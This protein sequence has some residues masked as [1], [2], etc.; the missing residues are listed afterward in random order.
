MEVGQNA[1]RQIVAPQKYQA[2]LLSLAHEAPLAGHLGIAKTRDRLLEHFYRPGIEKS[3]K[4]FCKSCETC[5]KVGKPNQTI[6]P[7]PL[8]PIPTTGEPFDRILMDCVGPLHKTRMGS[9]YILTI[10]CSAT[11]FPEAILLSHIHEKGNRCYDQFFLPE[12]DC[13]E[14]SWRIRV[15]ILCCDYLKELGIQHA[16]SSAYHPQSLGAL[17]R[18][19]STLKNMLRIHCLEHQ[20]NLVQGLPFVLFATRNAVQESLGFSPFALVYGRS[21]Q[22]PLQATKEQW[23]EPDPLPKE[24]SLYM[25]WLREN[26]SGAQDL[27]RS[28]LSKTLDKMKKYSTEKRES[29]NFRMVIKCCCYRQIEKHRSVKDFKDPTL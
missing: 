19:H 3:V 25:E 11:R 9:K 13:G 1:Y 12:L 21:M 16:R 23:I 28:N 5:Q 2:D 6:P 8:K 27:A 4:E 17:E 26:L 7:A 29:M 10:M 14:L 20:Q 22:G 15:L 24:P 18:F